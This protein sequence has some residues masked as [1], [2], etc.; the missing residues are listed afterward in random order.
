MSLPQ[1]RKNL[2]GLLVE[3]C[4]CYSW[5]VEN[6]QYELQRDIYNTK[7][8]SIRIAHQKIKEAKQKTIAS[9]DGKAMSANIEEIASGQTKVNM[10]E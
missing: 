4:Q 8:R 6:Q 5:N 1:T 9:S 2:E 7:C 10:N 3:E